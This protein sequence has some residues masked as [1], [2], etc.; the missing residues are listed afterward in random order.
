MVVQDRLALEVKNLPDEQ[1][2]LVA[3]Y[4]K[5]LKNRSLARN[6]K[7][8]LKERKKAFKDF[9]ELCVERRAGMDYK[10]ELEQ[11]LRE[12]YESLG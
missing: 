1:A 3:A 9:K 8:E 6:E 12:K 2:N 5:K 4:V 11:A 10:L 7:K